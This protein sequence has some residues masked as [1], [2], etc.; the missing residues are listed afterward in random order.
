MI[1]TPGFLDF[2]DEVYIA[3]NGEGYKTSEMRNGEFGMANN[4]WAKMNQ[5]SGSAANRKWSSKRF[6]GPTSN[7]KPE[8]RN[9]EPGT[10]DQQLGVFFLLTG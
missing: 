7:R 5:R 4:S 10:W 1:R 6:F 8:T 2:Q 3:E 9:Q